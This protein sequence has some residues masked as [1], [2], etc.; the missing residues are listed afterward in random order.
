MG[1]RIDKD[2]E[3][4]GIDQSEHAETA[5]DLSQSR[6]AVRRPKPARPAPRLG[7]AG[8]LVTRLVEAASRHQR[9]SERMKLV[10]AIIKPHQLETV[11]AAL[12]AYGISG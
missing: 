10:T 9:R 3:T 8:R 11:K 7:R 2:A 6:R 12:E 4:S 1:W 5:Y